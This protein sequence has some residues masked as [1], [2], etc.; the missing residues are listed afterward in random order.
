[1]NKTDFVGGEYLTE[2]ETAPEP[3]YHRGDL[4]GLPFNLK[5]MVSKYGKEI[6]P[7]EL[8][9]YHLFYNEM[10]VYI[11]ISKNI[12]GRLLQ[13]MK[14]PDMTF[15]NVLWFCGKDW[16]PDATMKD[17]IE[18]EYRMIK[19]MQPPLNQIYLHR[20]TT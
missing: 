7:A 15:N 19:E 18:I 9:L 1:M 20:K 3:Y 5:Q 10:L 17:M 12:R 16:K 13:H 11:G 2:I 8:G 14:N 4:I 6:I